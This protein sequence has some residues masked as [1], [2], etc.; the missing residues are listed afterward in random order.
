MKKYILRIKS[1]SSYYSHTATICR[2][3]EILTI[4]KLIVHRIATVMY[5]FNYG[6]LPDV[7]NTLYRKK[8]EIHFYNTRS[9]ESP[10]QY[11]LNN[12]LIIKYT[13]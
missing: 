13:K 10:K 11:L 1:S 9:E 3:L 8:C 5:K 6:I 12:V 2:D 4:D 7:L